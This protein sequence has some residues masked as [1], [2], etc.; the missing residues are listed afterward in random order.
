MRRSKLQIR[1]LAHLLEGPE[2]TVEALARSINRLRPSVSR[3]LHKLEKIGLVVKN[4]EGY[5]LTTQGEQ[6]AHKAREDTLENEVTVIFD[7][8]GQRCV[9]TFNGTSELT[10]LKWLE[11]MTEKGWLL[12]VE[13]IS[14]KTIHSQDELKEMFE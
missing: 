7:M 11:T 1:I 14:T 3:S 8:W 5:W 9:T 4:T 2:V 6:E 12:P 13:V 10:P